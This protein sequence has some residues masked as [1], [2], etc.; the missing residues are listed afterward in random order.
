MS[1]F[2]DE[3]REGYYD[4]R[5]GDCRGNNCHG[6]CHCCNQCSCCCV[7]PQGAVGP[8]GPQ[9][10]EGPQGATGPQGCM[11]PRG[12]PGPQGPEGPQGHR[13]AT[14]A[15]GD[16]GDKGE[17]GSRGEKGERGAT[18]TCC[19]A[20]AFGGMSHEEERCV[21]LYECQP[22]QVELCHKTEF[23]NLHIDLDKNCI[24]ILKDGIYELNFMLNA[25]MKHCVDIAVS[26]RANHKNISSAVVFNQKNGN[27]ICCQ[28]QT[29]V[30]LCKGDRIDLAITASHNTE[31]DFQ[32]KN[33]TVLLIKQVK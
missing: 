3:Y 11:G 22:K 33:S 18:G 6:G 10:I 25:T 8:Q 21:R 14:G 31:V 28:K 12:C 30:K 15:K 5:R 2:Y 7:G 16:K 27:I 13:G 29:F 1:N 23:C 26:A 20:V 19:C 4:E 17:R 9:G 32:C 24:T